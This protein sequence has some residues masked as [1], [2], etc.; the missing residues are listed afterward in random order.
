RRRDRGIDPAPWWLKVIGAAVA[1]YFILPTLI[2][3]PLSFS[4]KADFKFPPE[5]FSLRWYENFFTNP[6]WLTSLGNS[7]LVAVL[8]A[9][10]APVVGTAAARGLSRLTG[11]VAGFARALLMLS[12]VAPTIVVA[13]AVYTS[14]LQWHLTGTALGYVLAPAALGVPFV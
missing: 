10:L 2:V 11:R 5:G 7:I 12:L 14:F 4:E 1:L 8:A 13:V 6:A 3:I 9:N